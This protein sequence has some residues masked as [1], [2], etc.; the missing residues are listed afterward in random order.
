MCT[1]TCLKIYAFKDFSVIL[2]IVT[3]SECKTHKMCY[4]L[5]AALPAAW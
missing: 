3:D 2:Y 5:R 4:L 1:Q